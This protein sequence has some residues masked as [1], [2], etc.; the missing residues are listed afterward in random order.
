[1]HGGSGLSH[2]ILKKAILSGI[3]KINVNSDI[4]NVWHQEVVKF[5]NLNPNVY[6]PRKVIMS[7][8]NAMK[9]FIAHKINLLKEEK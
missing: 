3:S 6:D 5:I 2:S 4:Q 1:M 8:Q 9:E 7:G